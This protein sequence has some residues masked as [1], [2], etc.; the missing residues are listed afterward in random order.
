M[1][2]VA[3]KALTASA[4]MSL[5]GGVQQGR[6][7]KQA[8]NFNASQL[9]QR[10]QQS[11]VIGNAEAVARA[12]QTRQQAGA[13]RAALAANGVQVDSGTAADIVSDTFQIGAEDEAIIRNNAARAAWGF[14][15][16]AKQ[17]RYQGEAAAANQLVGGFATALT[18]GAQA[19]GYY[20]RRY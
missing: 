17:E 16:Q 13:Q 9:E 3:S 20:K 5:V 10:A 2:D 14:S 19:Y 8:G 15:E 6:L 11:L 1:C 18:T 7:S 4:M 12:R